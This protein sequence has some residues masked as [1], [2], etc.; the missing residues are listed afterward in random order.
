MVS[1]CRFGLGSQVEH[2]LLCT[3]AIYI[4]SLEKCLR[5]CISIFQLYLFLFLFG[6]A[7]WLA[8]SWFPDQG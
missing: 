8:G 7:S 1:C 4:S 6:G 5:K 3:L 2:L